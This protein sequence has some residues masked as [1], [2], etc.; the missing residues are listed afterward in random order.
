MFYVKNPLILYLKLQ[1]KFLFVE[2]VVE[3]GRIDADTLRGRFIFVFIIDVTMYDGKI[4]ICISLFHVAVERAEK[5][6]RHFS[7]VCS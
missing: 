1:G 5:R 4:V 2:M 3:R 6:E 7:F